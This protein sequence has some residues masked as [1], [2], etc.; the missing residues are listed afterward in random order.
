MK[1]VILVTGC[2]KGLGRAVAERL[3]A[4]DWTVYA[5]LRN[6]KE[7]SKLLRDWSKNYKNIT[8]VKLDITIEKDA[9]EVVSQILI[10]EGRIDVLINIAGYSITGATTGFETRDFTQILDTNV[11]G[12][13]R[14]IK[15]VAPQMKK[16]KDGKIINISSL[17]G[18]LSYPNFGLYSSS[19]FALDALSHALYYE[20]EKDGIDVIS[21]APGAI[22][23]KTGSMGIKTQKP[24]REKFFLLKYLLPM[25]DSKKIARVVMQAVND[26][27][28]PSRIVVG[29]DAKISY[30]LVKL[31]PTFLL[32]KLVLFLWNKK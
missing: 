6:L 12:A 29:V 24:L 11:V 20:L 10:K 7:S 19:K 22:K 21:I 9:K 3:A 32:D 8:P 5:G 28:P 18:F 30:L 15:A 14:L 27:N 4:G 16:Q 25:L 13:F 2:S 1:K 26:E 23:R 17:N 31:L